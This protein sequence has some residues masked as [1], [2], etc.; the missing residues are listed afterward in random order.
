MLHEMGN[1]SPLSLKYSLTF[2]PAHR[3]LSHTFNSVRVSH[4]RRHLLIAALKFRSHPWPAEYDFEW[5]QSKERRPVIQIQLN[6]IVGIEIQPFHFSITRNKSLICV[7]NHHKHFHHH[8]RR[9]RTI[10][11]SSPPGHVWK[12]PRL[13]INQREQT[14]IELVQVKVLRLTLPPL[15]PPMSLLRNN[16][17]SPPLATPSSTTTIPSI[18][19]TL[20]RL[21]LRSHHHSVHFS[22]T[23]FFLVFLVIPSDVFV[24]SP[25]HLF[26]NLHW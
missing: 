24:V 19:A 14:D 6:R 23:F 11:T 2:A 3:N 8:H 13:M 21:C 18:R 9:C 15:S 10:E 7:T 26:R 17:I 12:L 16:A 4:W 5:V 1:F 25:N 20:R 22:A